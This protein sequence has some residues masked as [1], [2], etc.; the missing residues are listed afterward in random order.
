MPGPGCR[1]F[2]RPDRPWAW[3]QP[4]VSELNLGLAS[5]RRGLEIFSGEAALLTVPHTQTQAELMARH[6]RPIS[7]AWGLRSDGLG[8][9]CSPHHSDPRACRR[10][11]GVCGVS[12]SLPPPS[13]WGGGAL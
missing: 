13:A 12:V 9:T 4:L 11:L 1:R 8:A 7:P 3:G 6:S 2:I 10:T 5:A